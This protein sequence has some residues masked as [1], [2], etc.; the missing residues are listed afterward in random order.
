MSQSAISRIWQAFALQPHRSET[1]KLSMRHPR[2]HLHFT[3]TG[4]CWDQRALVRHRN[5]NSVARSIAALENWNWLFQRYL[6]T[7]NQDPKPSANF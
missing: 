5:G 4:S 2:Y 6:E 7:Y 3:P 1:F